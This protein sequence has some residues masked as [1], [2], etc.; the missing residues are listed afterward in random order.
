MGGLV[1]AKVF[2]KAQEQRRRKIMPG[3]IVPM[4]CPTESL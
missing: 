3:A 2:E 1:A 4:Y